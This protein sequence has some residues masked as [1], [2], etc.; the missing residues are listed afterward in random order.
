[1]GYRLQ[2]RVGKQRVGKVNIACV[3]M[4]HWSPVTGIPRC[5]VIILNSRCS[6]LKRLKQGEEKQTSVTPLE[7]I[8]TLEKAIRNPPKY[9]ESLR[10]KFYLWLVFTAMYV[11]EKGAFDF[12]TERSVYQ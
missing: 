5:R 4:I 12:P 7:M 6:D 1:M 11:I 8:T 3:A 9:L 10:F 2:Q